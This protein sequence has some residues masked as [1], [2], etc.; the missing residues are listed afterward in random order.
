MSGGDSSQPIGAKGLARGSISEA[1]KRLGRRLSMGGSSL[2][3]RLFANQDSRQCD[4][5]IEQQEVSNLQDPAYNDEQEEEQQ[6]MRCLENPATLFNDQEYAKRHRQSIAVQTFF[7][8]S[9]ADDNEDDLEANRSTGLAES[10]V[11]QALKE[12]QNIELAQVDPPTTLSSCE[13]PEEAEVL[14]DSTTSGWTAP[15]TTVG[16]ESSSTTRSNGLENNQVISGGNIEAPVRPNALE[17]HWLGQKSKQ[18]N[19]GSVASDGVYII[20]RSSH[21]EATNLVGPDGAADHDYVKQLLL[22]HQHQMQP[23]SRPD[24]TR[25]VESIEE[26]ENGSHDHH[27][28][29]CLADLAVAHCSPT[30]VPTNTTTATTTTTT[31]TTTTNNNNL[32]SFTLITTDSN[33]SGSTNK[34]T[35]SSGTTNDELKQRPGSVKPVGFSV[36]LDS[37]Q[38]PHQQ[39]RAFSET[40]AYPAPE[41]HQRAAHSNHRQ[42]QRSCSNQANRAPSAASDP[43]RPGRTPAGCQQLDLGGSPAAGRHIRSADQ[44][45]RHQPGR[46][47]NSAG[48]NSAQGT[49]Q[50]VHQHPSGYRVHQQGSNRRQPA[51]TNQTGSSTSTSHTDSTHSHRPSLSNQ[52]EQ[53]PIA[54]GSARHVPDGWFTAAGRYQAQWR[55][56]NTFSS[57]L[58]SDISTSGHRDTTE[59]DSS[60]RTSTLSGISS[61][62]QQEI[63]L[64][65]TT[66]HSTPATSSSATGTNQPCVSMGS[67]PELSSID[68]CAQATKESPL[69]AQSQAGPTKPVVAG[70]NDC[71]GETAAQQ[72]DA[73]EPGSPINL[74]RVAATLRSQLR[75]FNALMGLNSADQDT[76]QVSAPEHQPARPCAPSNGAEP[77]GLAGANSTA[78]AGGDNHDPASGQRTSRTE[79]S[80]PASIK[81]FF[82]STSSAAFSAFTSSFQPQAHQSATSSTSTMTAPTV[83]HRHPLPSATS[84]TGLFGSKSLSGEVFEVVGSSATSSILVANSQSP[85]STTS[86]STPGYKL[87]SCPDP[88]IQSQLNSSNNGARSPLSPL[89]A[90]PTRFF[91]RIR[92][93]FTLSPTGRPGSAAT[94]SASTSTQPV[95]A[96]SATRTLDESSMLK[97]PTIEECEEE[98]AS[99]RRDQSIDTMSMLD[100]SLTEQQPVGNQRAGSTSSTGPLLAMTGDESDAPE[101]PSSSLG[102]RKFQLDDDYERLVSS[103]RPSFQRQLDEQVNQVYRMAVERKLQN[104][105]IAEFES[106]ALA[107]TANDPSCLDSLKA[108]QAGQSDLSSIIRPAGCIVSNQSELTGRGLVA[109]AGHNNNN[110]G[111]SIYLPCN[112]Q[113]LQHEPAG[114]QEQ[115]RWIEESQLSMDSSSSVRSLRSCWFSMPELYV[116]NR[117]SSSQS[118]SGAGPAQPVQVAPPIGTNIAPWTDTLTNNLLAPSGCNQLGLFSSPDKAASE[119]GTRWPTDQLCRQITG[120][121]QN[122]SLSDLNLT[123]DDIAPLEMLRKPGND[124]KDANQLNRIALE[125]IKGSTLDDSVCVSMRSNSTSR[126]QENPQ[127]IEGGL[128]PASR[129]TSQNSTISSTSCALSDMNCSADAQDIGPRTSDDSNSVSPAQQ[130]CNRP[131]SLSPLPQCLVTGDSDPFP[132]GLKQRAM[133]LMPDTRLVHDSGATSP[134]GPG[135]LLNVA[136]QRP[137]RRSAMGNLMRADVAPAVA[138]LDLRL[139]A[140]RNRVKLSDLHPITFINDRKFLDTMSSIKNAGD[141]KL[142]AIFNG[143][144]GRRLSVNAEL[145]KQA[146]SAQNKSSIKIGLTGY[147]Y[148][149]RDQQWLDRSQHLSS[150]DSKVSDHIRRPSLAP[151]FWRDTRASS[152]TP[153]VSTGSGSLTS[154]FQIPNRPRSA[155]LVPAVSI[156]TP[157]SSTAKRSEFLFDGV[158]HSSVDPHHAPRRGDQQSKADYTERPFSTLSKIGENEVLKAPERAP[159]EGDVDS[160]G[161]DGS[162][163]RFVHFKPGRRREHDEQTSCTGTIT[164]TTNSDGSSGSDDDAAHDRDGNASASSSSDDGDLDKLIAQYPSVGYSELSNTSAYGNQN[165]ALNQHALAPNAQRRQRSRSIAQPSGRVVKN[166]MILHQLLLANNAASLTAASDDR[167]RASSSEGSRARRFSAINL[168]QRDNDVFVA[169]SMKR[170][171]SNQLQLLS[172]LPLLAGT[173]PV[174]PASSSISVEQ[175]TMGAQ[176]PLL[177]RS[178]VGQ[179]GIK[180]IISGSSGLNRSPA[181]VDA[182]S[183]PSS[184]SSYVSST[185]VA[186]VDVEEQLNRLRQQEKRSMAFMQSF[187]S[188]FGGQ[189]GAA[190][191]SPVGDRST[192]DLAQELVEE[193]EEEQEDDEEGEQGEEEEEEQEDEVSSTSSDVLGDVE[194]PSKPTIPSI[195]RQ[196]GMPDP[197][198][199]Q[200]GQVEVELAERKTGQRSPVALNAPRSPPHSPLSL[201]LSGGAGTL[202]TPANLLLL[203]GRPDSLGYSGSKSCEPFKQLDTIIEGRG[204]L[205]GAEQQADPSYANRL[206]RLSG[207]HSRR[208]SL[209]NSSQRGESLE[210][211]GSAND[212]CQCDLSPTRSRPPVRVNSSAD[213]NSTRPATKGGASGRHIEPQA[214]ASSSSRSML[215]TMRSIAR[216]TLTNL[217]TSMV[218]PPII[219]PGQHASSS[220][221]N[222]QAAQVKIDGQPGL[223]NQPAHGRPHDRQRSRSMVVGT[224]GQV[225]TS[226]PMIPSDLLREKARQAEQR[227]SEQLGA[228]RADCQALGSTGSSS[229]LSTGSPDSSSLSSLDD[230]ENYRTKNKDNKMKHGRSLERSS[231]ESSLSSERSSNLVQDKCNR[232]ERSNETKQITGGA[233]RAEE[234][235]D[236]EEVEYDDDDADLN[237]SDEEYLNDQDEEDEGEDE[238]EEMPKI[239]YK[240]NKKLPSHYYGHKPADQQAGLNEQL[241]DGPSGE[242]GAQQP[243]EASEEPLNSLAPSDKSLEPAGSRSQ[244]DLVGLGRHRPGRRRNSSAR[245]SASISAADISDSNPAGIHFNRRKNKWHIQRNLAPKLKRQRSFSA[246]YAPVS[247]CHR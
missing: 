223:R 162:N 179:S 202:S 239:C 90:T 247:S 220:S 190:G 11:G 155:S 116:M 117:D 147:I 221:A 128:Q 172:T 145:A 218:V 88:G 45:V 41:L 120:E 204:L 51:S 126:E 20:P 23:S 56:S 61:I 195:L 95:T 19:Y 109:L 199:D 43:D 31:T 91:A 231:S 85:R 101:G 214:S 34:T 57:S 16:L 222:E 44:A 208:S 200:E 196:P 139:A 62:Y 188:D 236:E 240:C 1:A 136:S 184:A 96:I 69:A 232:A 168:Y 219:V 48:T 83:L 58:N 203:S 28:S 70:D 15:T 224:S 215:D 158:K 40:E 68:D 167:C 14:S 54:V 143:P 22:Q 148:I 97:K 108:R 4:I 52:P 242:L 151:N 105:P 124:V 100:S 33:T 159:Y 74:Q 3:G 84:S 104:S 17:S 118:P 77:S 32:S 137:R 171:P 2:F 111:L 9:I 37:P 198:Q 79:S 80:T 64:P 129:P 140:R 230:A 47:V 122:W 206:R 186:G 113:H 87:A 174:L 39:R 154:H 6:R 65:F 81:S 35:T 110:S 181:C 24:R 210:D 244:R 197:D 7:T 66:P 53:E 46:K 5:R 106:L 185:L 205:L 71:P 157:E 21:S 26:E 38:A 207:N 27:L 233:H 161:S 63:G 246:N 216:R 98:T 169:N 156:R 114:D 175:K 36:P 99:G 119:T 142:N 86:V 103:R 234:V 49:Y 94:S 75:S 226:Q 123:S 55:H 89:T 152:P 125:L 182:T 229:S 76:S 160:A 92:D 29:G 189:L 177:S 10:T 176:L 241:V 237:D 183:S 138:T 30:T 102:K 18:T 211:Q 164:S 107:S 153:K 213:T 130:E 227:R 112:K 67:I 212:W 25:Q 245:R 132:G 166:E 225:N 180:S 131:T 121:R 12:H 243:T 209:G 127:P 149:D 201:L 134:V 150:V 217:A 192:T 8:K 193:A 163:Y 228:H 82:R 93:R 133:S 146:T 141:H 73:V 235:D 78:V 13:E 115:A 194:V 60:R 170:P 72:G 59:K 173:L 165:S 178:T 50:R 144:V 135:G 238:E 42:Q 187:S 191:Q